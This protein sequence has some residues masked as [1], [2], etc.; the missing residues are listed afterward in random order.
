MKLKLNSCILFLFFSF[1]YILSETL[2]FKL[3]QTF[4]LKKEINEISD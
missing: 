4:D 1:I 3:R 2:N